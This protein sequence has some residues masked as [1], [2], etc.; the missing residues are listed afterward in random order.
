MINW[1]EI[2]RVLLPSIITAGT[3]LISLKILRKNI[4]K[5]NTKWGSASLNERPGVYQAYV[6]ELI[7]EVLEIINEKSLLKN[8]RRQIIKRSVRLWRHQIAVGIFEEMSLTGATSEGLVKN[9]IYRYLMSVLDLIGNE[10]VGIIMTHAEKNGFSELYSEAEKNIFLSERVKEVET[11]IIEALES[12]YLVSDNSIITQ[13]NIKEWIK[14]RRVSSEQIW[15]NLYRQII[16]V[17]IET[18]SKLW[19][20]IERITIKGLN[21]GLT[22]DEIDNIR[23]LFKRSI[24]EKL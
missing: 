21:N 17:T 1:T 7:I 6:I 19:S 2:L 23:N 14:N 10:L 3:L 20:Y 13:E 22:D 24:I 4:K 16:D 15:T 11:F 8:K 5:I 18:K 12:N 9:P